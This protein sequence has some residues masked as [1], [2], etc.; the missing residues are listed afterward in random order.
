M[1][2]PAPFRFSGLAVGLQTLLDLFRAQSSA[3]VDAALSDNVLDGG[4]VGR[5]ELG[6]S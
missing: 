4:S 5:K 6:A 3:W 2:R 1:G